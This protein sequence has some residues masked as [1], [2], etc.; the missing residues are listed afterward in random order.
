M[1]CGLSFA[2][3]SASFTAQLKPTQT[4]EAL[5]MSLLIGESNIVNTIAKRSLFVIMIS[6]LKKY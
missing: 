4:T 3:R 1:A 2:R 5:A 6:R